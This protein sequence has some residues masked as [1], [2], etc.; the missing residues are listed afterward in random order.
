VSFTYGADVRARWVAAALTLA[1]GCVSADEAEVLSDPEPELVLIVRGTGAGG[2]DV[3]VLE[4]PQREA[5]VTEVGTATVHVLLYDRSLSELSLRADL[6]RLVQRRGGIPL[7]RPQRWLALRAGREP[8]ALD[9]N[10]VDTAAVFPELRVPPRPCE[11]LREDRTLRLDELSDVLDLTVVAALDERRSLVGA[12]DLVGEPFLALTVD[13]GLARLPLR[14]GPQPALGF[15]D[16]ADGSLW[17]ALE[18]VDSSTTTPRPALCHFA[19]GGPFDER[20]CRPSELGRSSVRLQQLTG[21]RAPGGSLQLAALDDV[22]AVHVWRTS[23]AA[24]ARW[25][26]ALS[27]GIW[28]DPACA[29]DAASRRVVLDGPDTGWVTAEGGYLVRFDLSRPQ[30]PGE[31]LFDRPS[32]RAYYTRHPLGH[33]L[34]VRVE[35]ASEGGTFDTPAE[36][37]VRAPGERAWVRTNDPEAAALE[38]NGM[39]VV[40][41]TVLV[42]GEADV[43]VPWVLDPQRPDAPPRRCTPAAVYN[44]GSRM[45]ASPDGQLLIA[46]KLPNPGGLGLRA[47]GRWRLVP[48]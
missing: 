12:V 25:T 29:P 9:P 40:G 38:P 37:W 28:R 22:G 36:L 1:A 31:R 13:D 17:V 16:P 7:P 30:L 46:G 32:C 4:R 26:P 15:V 10:S 33:E 47:V 39:L 5:W 41:N 35:Y 23:S 20:A 42:T 44:D 45:W 43:V 21:Y 19:L 3:D 6:G 48:E 14:L 2:V 24:V 27:T 18:Q 8:R 11:G 34:L